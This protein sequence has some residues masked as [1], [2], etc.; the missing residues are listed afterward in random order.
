MRLRVLLP[1]LLGTSCGGHPSPVPDAR[2]HVA[3]PDA[4]APADAGPLTPSVDFTVANC[5]NLDPSVPSCTG[6][7][8][9][10]V[11]FT[12]VAT[13]DISKFIW[14]FGDN[15]PPNEESVAPS[16]TYTTRGPFDVTLIGLGATSSAPPHMTHPGFIVALADKAGGPC[17]AD[18]ECAE[19]LQCICSSAKPCTTGPVNGMCTSPCD[20]SDDC[21]DGTLCTNLV[22]AIANSGG[23]EPWQTRIC[24]AACQ[25]DAD[26]RPGL[27]CRT[28][29]AW[30]N[31]AASVH[32]CF[33]DVPADLGAPCMDAHHVRRNDLCVTGLCADL[34][35]LGQCSRDCTSTVCP[36]GSD[37]AVFG[38]G[39]ELCLVPCSAAFPCDQDPL[40]TCAAAGDS[41]LGYQLKAPAGPGTPYCA[42]MNCSNDTECGAAGLCRLDSGG[43]HCVAR[44]KIGS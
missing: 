18:L 28:L 37:C 20:K 16:H 33:S 39:R 10:T 14:T 7:V 44:P 29:P 38:D 8:P 22:T 15:T 36:I 34:G 30:P 3:F 19:G 13:P 24:L 4:A 40:L 1:F 31:G 12:P 9:F 11:Q 32:A 41:L 42:P 5:P 6:T 27:R 26:C 21:P 25:A 43:G 35:A 2:P 23:A 17:Q